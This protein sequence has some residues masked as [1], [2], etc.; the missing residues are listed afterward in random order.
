MSDEI[1]VVRLGSSLP[2]MPTSNKEMCRVYGLGLHVWSLEWGITFTNIK[3]EETRESDTTCHP[4]CSQQ[5][6]PQKHAVT[7]KDQDVR[8]GMTKNEY[9]TTS[10]ERTADITQAL[11]PTNPDSKTDFGANKESN[12]IS[13]KTA[14]ISCSTRCNLKP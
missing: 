7:K 1:Q 10:A 13:P 11:C 5:F 4:V 6:N 12:R 8:V 2:T 3:C 9:P 14:S